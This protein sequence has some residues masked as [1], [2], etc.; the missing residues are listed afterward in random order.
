MFDRGM[1]LVAGPAAVAFGHGAGGLAVGVVAVVGPLIGIARRIFYFDGETDQIGLIVALLVDRAAA[2]CVTLID[3]EHGLLRPL[4]GI[5]ELVV[6]PALHEYVG[7]HFMAAGRGTVVHAESSGE[8]HPFAVVG[9]AE[10]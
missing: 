4:S 7:E 8:K 1:G 9:G 10:K 5:H 2:G 6:G 3:H